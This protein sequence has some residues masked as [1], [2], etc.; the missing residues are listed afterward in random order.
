MN[1]HQ[2]MASLIS[3]IPDDFAI[4]F[5]GKYL[6]FSCK[7]KG[8]LFL[9][10]GPFNISFS[11]GMILPVKKNVFIFCDDAYAIRNLS[12]F[13]QLAASKCKNL[14]VCLLVSGVYNG[15]HSPTIFSGVNS[16]YSLFHGLGFFTFD[17]TK[18]INQNNIKAIELGITRNN[19]PIIILIDIESDNK[20]PKKANMVS[21]RNM[22]EF[23]NF[24]QA[25]E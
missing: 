18:Y 14:Y 19:G 8:I 23:I 3:V 1:K 24:L 9:D 25:E 2:A 16:K 15:V 4:I 22:T 11:L 10:D 21:K 5:I 6:H 17:Y 20:K 13:M 12:E 7:R